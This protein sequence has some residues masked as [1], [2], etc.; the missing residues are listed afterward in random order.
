MTQDQA[1]ASLEKQGLSFKTLGDGQTVTAQVPAPGNTVP[2]NSEI[3]LYFGNQIETQQVCVP[4][5]IGMTRQAAQQRAAELGLYILVSGNWGTELTV[6]VTEQ[7]IPPET[8]VPLGTTIE[9]KF[10]D[11]KATG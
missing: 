6:M 9:L 5:F 11:T 10:I 8:E 7:S 2:S 3:L 1:K 4:D